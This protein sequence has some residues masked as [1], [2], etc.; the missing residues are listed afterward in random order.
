[1]IGPKSSSQTR[2]ASGTQRLTG[3]ALFVALA[4]ILNFLVRVP[5][6]VPAANFLLLEVWEIPLV[7]A[8]LLFGVRAGLL[9]A[10]VNTVIL[11][12][13]GSPGPPS[14]PFYNLA[15][16]ALTFSGVIIG[17]GVATRLKLTLSGMIVLATVFAVSLRVTGMTVINYVFD[18]L[19]PPIG[20]AYPLQ[21]IVPLL[22]AIALFNATIV[23]YTVPISYWIIKEVASRY[24]IKTVF[25]LPEKS[26]PIVSGQSK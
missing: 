24:R 19:P 22:P 17:H 4:I 15:A 7:A 10:I 3:M 11:F 5:F 23:L 9:V 8:L 18:P 16:V 2:Y 20:L 25:A 13:I 12:F 1:M 21:V 14:G 6:F 26:Q